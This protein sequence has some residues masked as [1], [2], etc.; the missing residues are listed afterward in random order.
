MIAKICID[1][2][3]YRLI[4]CH[5]LSSVLFFGH[6]KHVVHH[7][8]LSCWLAGH[9]TPPVMGLQGGVSQFH[10]APEFDFLISAAFHANE[11]LE[12]SEHF[13]TSQMPHS[14]SLTFSFCQNFNRSESA[15]NIP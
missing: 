9:F 8:T 1:F 7:I 14:R 10:F 5:S 11:T 4:K 2:L 12:I 15:D 13:D 6:K 3:D